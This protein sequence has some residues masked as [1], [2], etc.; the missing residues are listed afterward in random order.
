MLD[1]SVTLPWCF[2]DETSEY[3][4]RI[5]DRLPG[6]LAHTTHMWPLE[7][8]NAFV[9]AER[10]RRT[11]PA[12]TVRYLTFLRPLPIQVHPYD[13]ETAFGRT[14]LLSRSYGL[15]SYDAGYLE[16]ALRLGLPIATLDK[17]LRAAAVAVG[18][19]FFAD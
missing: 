7:L 9:V 18:V 10:R 4:D 15:T 6:N 8:I 3:A 14:L 11:L 13:W 1:A 12:D 19:P 2:Q 5:L 17:A 16:L